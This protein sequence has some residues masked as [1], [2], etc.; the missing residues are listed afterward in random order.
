MVDIYFFKGLLNLGSKACEIILRILKDWEVCAVDAKGLFVGLVVVWNPRMCNFN[1]FKNWGSQ[2]SLDL[3]DTYFLHLFTKY[4]LVDIFHTKL[5][6]TWK[7]R[8]KEGEGVGKRLDIFFM[9]DYV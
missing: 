4:Q 3:M 9:K 6:P 8:K 5:Y 2:T 7:I 1:P